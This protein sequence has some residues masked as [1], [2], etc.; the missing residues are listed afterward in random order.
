MSD[1]VPEESRLAMIARRYQAK[2]IDAFLEAQRSFKAE[3]EALVSEIANVKRTRDELL[4]DY[5]GFQL[6]VRA[7]LG[8]PDDGVPFVEHIKRMR[9]EL[10]AI[11]R[12]IPSLH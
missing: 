12:D 4:C 1:A 11:K 8:C 3:C 6:E 2:N 10:A 7:A 9:E 5:D